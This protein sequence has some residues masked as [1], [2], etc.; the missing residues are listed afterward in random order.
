MDIDYKIQ[1]EMLRRG[2]SSRTIGT[3]LACIHKFF[4]KCSKEPSKVSK[5]EVREYINDLIKKDAAGNTINVYLNALKFFFEEILNKRMK[6]N[7]RYSKTPKRLPVV[8]AKDETKRLIDSIG[9][10]KHRLMI[11][12][13]YSAGLRVSELVNL[14]IKDFEFE[15]NHGWVR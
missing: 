4:T 1:R 11:K 6:L 8:L 12:L 7:I 9:N 2:Y 10:N 3:Y 13:M 14:K 5:T 15:N